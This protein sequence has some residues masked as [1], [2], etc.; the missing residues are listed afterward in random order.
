MKRVLLL[1]SLYILTN[2]LFAQNEG[3]IWYFGAQ[4]GLDFN[5]G[6]P[7]VLTNSKMFADE[8]CAVMSNSAGNLLFYTR[9]DTVWNRNHLPMA[10]GTNIMGCWSSSQGVIILP[11]PNLAGYYYIFTVDCAEDSL[12]A[13]LRYSVVQMSLNGGLGGVTVKNQL[14]TPMVTEKITAVKHA[15]GT[16]Y[17][18][19]THEYN[20]NRFFVHQ[21]NS[22]GINVTPQTFNIGSVHGTPPPY[23]GASGS[24]NASHDGSKLAVTIMG[25]NIIEIFDFDNTTGTISNPLTFPQNWFGPYSIEFSPS[26]DRV[27]FSVLDAKIY[28]IDLLAGTPADIINSVTQVGTHV[29]YLLPVT[30]TLQIGPDGKIYVACP[31]DTTLAVI[32]YPDGLGTSCNFMDHHVD[33]AG[34]YSWFGLPQIFYDPLVYVDFTATQHCFGDST[35]FTVQD[36]TSNGI[37]SVYWNFGDPLS[38]V[39]NFSTLLN[40]KHLF[41]SSGTFDVKLVYYFNGTVDSILKPVLICN[42]PN[43]NLGKDTIFCAGSSLKLDAGQGVNYMWS[44]GS[45]TQ[46]INVTSGGQYIVTATNCPGCSKSDTINVS[47]LPGPVVDLGPNQIIYQGNTTTL[48]AGFFPNCSYLWYPD[49]QTTT[50][51]IVD[52]TG[53]YSVVVTDTI[54]GCSDSSSIFITLILNLCYTQVDFNTWI[55]E[56]DP[57]Y[58]N[59]VVQGGGTSV[60]QTINGD[61]TFFVTPDTLM[62]VVISGKITV[63][64][65]GAGIFN[66]PDDDWVGFVFGYKE[67]NNNT[68]YDDYDFYLFD[69]KMAWQQ[70]NSG[71]NSYVGQEGFSLCKVD[72]NIATQNDLYKYF[73]AHTNDGN[74][75]QVIDS[76]W[77][78][79]YGWTRYQEYRFELTYT[80]TRIIVV[81]DWD[82]IFDINGCF[83]AGRFG[84]YNYSQREVLY[85][86][87][88]YRLK[89]DFSPTESCF[90]ETVEFISV[91]TSCTTIPPNLQNWVWDFGNG[92]SSTMVNPVYTYPAPGNYTVKLIIDDYLGCND[93]IAKVFNVWP[94][95]D[96]IPYPSDTVLCLGDSVVL[97]ATGASTYEWSPVTGLSGSTGSVVTAKPTVATTYT[98]IGTDTLGCK[99]MDSIIVDMNPPMFNQINFSDVSCFGYNDAWAKIFVNG[100][101]PPMMYEWNTGDL[102]DSITGLSPTTYTV[103]VTDYYKCTTVDSVTITQPSLLT[104]SIIDSTDV[105]CFGGSDGT[106]TVLANGGTPGYTYNWSTSPPQSGQTA[107]NLS[108][109]QYFVYVTDTNGC[110]TTISV[111]IGQPDQLFISI[112]DEDEGC[113][114][115]CTGSIVATVTGGIRPYSYAWS[116]P[117]V[118]VDSVVTNLC[119]GNYYLTITDFNNCPLSSGLI[120]IGTAVPIDATFIAD[121]V[122]GYAPLD[123]NFSFVGAEAQEYQ[124]DFGDGTSDTI[125]NPSHVYNADGDFIVTLIIN[126]GYPYFCTD[127]FSLTISVDATPFMD[128]PN[129]F[130]PNNDGYNDVF[131][132]ETRGLIAFNCMIYNRWGKKIYEWSGA[133]GFWDGKQNGNEAADG[134]YFYIIN[135]KGNDGKD[136]KEQ[137]SVTLMRGN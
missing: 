9:G 118:V 18:I 17:W 96:I 91:D 88:N 49:G 68:S 117:I 87:F 6:S 40:P 109:I 74:K 34:R 137:G 58:G 77:G 112:A 79:G 63:L 132:I 36:Y 104:A 29:N 19:I 16:D 2:V 30:A 61:P 121:P 83:E 80:S 75:F 15:N 111:F 4:A 94:T 56:A 95:P 97:T 107:T 134:V 103:T 13:G 48:D 116:S 78:P 92:D 5:G 27:Y 44:N 86:D 54:S 8:G 31:Y 93:S 135:A 98:I 73:W 23:T 123:V 57:G 128:I 129:A 10:N 12:A 84:F 66:P 71:G 38:G 21:L 11:L 72:G 42:K 69:W 136:Y 22:A 70:V 110:D 105:S 130:S 65:D 53:T 32:D 20:T 7:V 81:M 115:S 14:L 51:I 64:D 76:L 60:F 120:S 59:W 106:A 35:L 82:T 41:S 24:I 99:G 100:G 89:I 113:P 127:T 102:T 33:L 28:Q 45:T 37:D 90:G 62:N 67:P 43:V 25:N 52:T 47:V 125:P 119:Q 26:N 46:T 124:W 1:L 131:R 122:M 133:D 50:S 55:E 114:G 85:E 39:G 126:S 108:A 3:N 101:T